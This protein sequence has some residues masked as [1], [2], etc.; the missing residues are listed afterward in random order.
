MGAVALGGVPGLDKELAEARARGQHN[1]RGFRRLFAALGHQR[2]IGLNAR[3]ALGLA[4][5]RALAHPFELAL[6]GALA[7]GFLLALL[8]QA[9]LLL[10]EPARVI[11]L[12]GN[13]A[14]AVELEDP[15][16][17]VV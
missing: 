16:R 7:R 3:L 14:A 9:L 4:G 1:L 15:A 13:P 6:E 8:R 10:L 2:L 5:A 12:V 17:D 11:S